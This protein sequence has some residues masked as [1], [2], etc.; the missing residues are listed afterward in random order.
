M[1]E[2]ITKQEKKVKKL[3]QNLGLRRGKST[4]RRDDALGGLS[5]HEH[6]LRLGKFTGRLINALGRLGFSQ[7]P[8]GAA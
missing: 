2:P 6:P 8:L 7:N 3:Q 5:P 1:E 4:G